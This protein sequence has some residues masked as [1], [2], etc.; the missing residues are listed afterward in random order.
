V[1]RVRWRVEKR[2][3]NQWMYLEE[4]DGQED[5]RKEGTLRRFM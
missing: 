2:L 3:A 1:L 4:V 5:I